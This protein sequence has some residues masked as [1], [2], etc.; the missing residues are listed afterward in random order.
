MRV[1]ECA[2]VCVCVCV[3]VCVRACVCVCVRKCVRVCA[4][5]SVCVC[6][7]VCVCV[8]VC[9]CVCMCVCVCVCVFVCVCVCLCVCVCVLMYLTPVPDVVSVRLKHLDLVH[10]IVVVHADEHVVRASDYPLLP[11]HELGSPNW[12][13]RDFERLYEGLDGWRVRC[14][15]RS[16]NKRVKRALISALAKMTAS[17]VCFAPLCSGTPCCYALRTVSV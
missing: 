15:H 14:G 5:V 4:C 9:V 17:V 7:Y 6:V 12:L 10:R 1:C 16:R 13:L 2:C 3:L 11:C 8:R